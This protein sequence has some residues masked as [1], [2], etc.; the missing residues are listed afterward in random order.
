MDLVVTRLTTAGT[1]KFSKCRLLLF[2]NPSV[3]K[4][5]T[6]L[7]TAAPVLTAI[8]LRLSESDRNIPGLIA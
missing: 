5:F 8:C 2:P 3:N 1:A 4:D 7:P 6:L